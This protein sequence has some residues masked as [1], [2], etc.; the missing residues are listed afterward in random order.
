MDHVLEVMGNPAACRGPPTTQNWVWGTWGSR[1][2]Q[3]R[4][5]D[6]FGSGQAIKTQ[7]NE[8]ISN[9]A[10]HTLLGPII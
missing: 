10:S 9:A 8:A 1:D 4:A 3:P 6:Q 5:V 7:A 2:P